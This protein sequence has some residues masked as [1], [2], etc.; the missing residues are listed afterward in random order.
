MKEYF[1]LKLLF[2]LTI[3]G[4]SLQSCSD[5][6]LKCSSDDVC[7]LCD[8]INFYIPKDKDCIK[9]DVPNCEIIDVTGNCLKCKSN[10]FLE[11]KD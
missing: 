7:I 11:S 8:A 1:K 9:K 10:Y 4:Q 6:C 5:K 3:I 2:I